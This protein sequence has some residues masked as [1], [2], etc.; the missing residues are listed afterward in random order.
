MPD[1][2]AAGTG[3]YAASSRTP[4]DRNGEMALRRFEELQPLGRGFF[5]QVVKV[6][7][8]KTGQLYAL[9][10]VPKSLLR[11]YKVEDKIVQE[12]HIMYRLKHPNIVKLEFH[13]EDADNKYLA[14]EFACGGE[15][16]AKMRRAPGKRFGHKQAAR[17]FYE[18]LDAL[19]Y[20]HTQE[21]KI[22]H[23]DLKP[24]N[25]LLDGEDR[26]K[27]CDFGYSKSL[28]AGEMGMSFV[29]TLDYLAPEMVQNL[30]HDETVDCWAM[31][32]LLWEMVVSVSPFAAGDQRRT[33]AKILKRELTFPPDLDADAKDL[34]D[35]MLQLKPANRPSMATAMKH[36]YM[37]KFGPHKKDQEPVPNVE[38]S[39][40]GQLTV[41]VGPGTPVATASPEER[42]AAKAELSKQV[43]KLELQAQQLRNELESKNKRLQSLEGDKVGELEAR[44]GHLTTQNAVLRDHMEDFGRMGLTPQVLESL[45]AFTREKLVEQVRQHVSLMMDVS[46]KVQSSRR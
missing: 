31:G 23:R 12:I 19:N 29:G 5:G 27:L 28:A 36:P 42:A 41:S 43:E 21:P 8:R 40:D 10:K 35:K 24:E 16:M 30:P 26:I 46:Q 22:A 32:V 33:F 9:K 37:L 20:L 38:V 13:F 2:R 11:R 14:L 45:E 18:C 44:I 1:P 4:A 17:Y 34:I 39:T 3:G 6:R 15:L 25:I 7:D